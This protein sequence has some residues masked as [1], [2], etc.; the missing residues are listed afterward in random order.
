MYDFTDLFCRA[1]SNYF[2]I[3]NSW[4]GDMNYFTSFLRNYSQVDVP[5]INDFVATSCRYQVSADFLSN[6]AAKFI[7]SF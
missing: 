6:V 3:A 4:S 5:G 7:C 2:R 1:S